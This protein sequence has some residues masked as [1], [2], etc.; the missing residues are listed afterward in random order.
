MKKIVWTLLLA[1]MSASAFKSYAQQEISLDVPRIVP[2]TPTAAGMEK[3]QTYP[4][5]YCTG[6][7]NITIPLYEIIAGEVTIPITLSYH[8]SGIKPKERSGLAGTGWTLNL[9]PSISRQ[10]NGVNDADYYGWFSRGYSQNQVP[11]NNKEKLIYYG[12]MVDNKRDTHPDKFTYKLPNGGG[13]GYF[14]NSFDPLIT[15][16]RNNDHVRY[17]GNNMEITDEKGIRYLFNGVVEK[18]SDVITRWMCTSINSSRKPSQTLVSFQYQ[19]IPNLMN[20]NSFYNLDDK[21][22]FDSNIVI[23]QKTNAVNYYLLTAP[24]VPGSM[25]E[26]PDAVVTRISEKDVETKFPATERYVSGYMNIARITGVEFLGNHL[27]VSY[28]SVGVVPHNGDVIDEIE[29]TDEN[30]AV[31]R[32]IKLYITPYNSRTSLTKLDSVKISVSGAEPRIYSFSYYSNNSVPSI[33]TTTVD[34]WGFC[35]GAEGRSQGQSNVPAF[36]KKVTFPDRNGY[37]TTEMVMFNYSGAD[38]E[39]N[40]VWTKTGILERITDPEGIITTFSYEGNYGAFRDNRKSFDKRDYLHPVGG[41]RIE[42]IETLDSKTREKITKQYWYGLTKLG[43]PT[44]EPIW[45]GGAIKHIV[46]ENDYCSQI[47][48]HKHSIADSRFEPLTTYNSM[49]ISNISFNN[50]S[51]VMYNIVKEEITSNTTRDEQKTNYYYHVNLHNFEDVL[52]WDDNNVTASVKS[53]FSDQPMDVARKIARVLP[54][55]PREPSDDFLRNER[56]TNQYYGALVRTEIF[57][58]NDITVSKDYIY[59]EKRVWSSNINIDIPVRLLIADIDYY[60]QQGFYQP[61][62]EIKNYYSQPGEGIQT[63]YYLDS[64]ICRVL[65]AEITKEYFDISGRKEVVVTEKRYG[66]LPSNYTPSISL[67]PS[68]IEVINS[69]SSRVMDQYNYLENFPGIVSYHKHAEDKGWKES[70]ILFRAGTCL[71]D[72]VQVRTSLSPEYSNEV[73]YKSYDSNNNVAEIM[74]KDGI[75]IFFIWGY[76]NQFPI[77]KIENATRQQVAKAL[78]YGENEYSIFSTW[79]TYAK[80]TTDV[81]AKLNSLRKL[82]PDARVT[83]YEYSPLQGVVAITEPNGFIS[84]FD[85]D[86]YNRLVNSSFLDDDGQKKMLKQYIYNFIRQ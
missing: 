86:N 79:A 68:E 65:D 51:A 43:D 39:P 81:W 85:Y 30:G 42:R 10:V 25:T 76:R 17:Y 20:P 40:Y 74:G 50:G 73:I 36:R 77:A 3:Y 54:A 16:P 28:K 61:M 32:N 35:N 84:K 60:L 80:P 1:C 56:E 82:L 41:L 23:E 46:T 70:R 53:F 2:I 37:G 66:Y 69:D 15:I 6:I 29:V 63:M 75:S 67:K 9:E 21:L 62:F 52:K 45:G 59:K 38:R 4:V 18:T 72:T 57:K 26:V 31:V 12:E 24:H 33:Y 78:G 55:H 22:V 34:H 64:G 7:P 71:P 5:D 58:G 19:T 8:A 44:Y 83:T 48:L 13:S 49:P 11:L 27:T 14:F 47:T